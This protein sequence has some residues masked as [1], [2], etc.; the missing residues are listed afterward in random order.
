MTRTPTKLNVRVYLGDVEIGPSELTNLII[1]NKTV[2]RIVNAAADRMCH[3]CD[4]DLAV[5]G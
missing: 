2:D 4:D 5:S 3:A 1:N